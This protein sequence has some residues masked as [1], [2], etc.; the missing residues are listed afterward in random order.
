MKN[1]EC[2]TFTDRTKYDEPRDTGQKDM[3]DRALDSRNIMEGTW[4][5]PRIKFYQPYSRTPS[6][7]FQSN[8]FNSLGRLSCVVFE[9]VVLSK[10]A[11]LES[12]L[13]A[14]LS[15]ESNPP[16]PN[17]THPTLYLLNLSRKLIFNRSIGDVKLTMF[18]DR[19]ERFGWL[20]SVPILVS[21]LLL[22][23]QSLLDTPSRD[24]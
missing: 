20:F 24:V 22:S 6:Q 11:S 18:A 2:L 4:N 15:P 17:F 16:V 23:P 5:I 7:M 21:I 8:N 12:Q 9:K 14:D 10:C 3:I 19:G 13:S 1:C